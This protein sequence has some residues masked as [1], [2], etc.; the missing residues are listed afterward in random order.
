MGK[1]RS[2]SEFTIPGLGHPAI[3]GQLYDGSKDSFVSTPQAW[4]DQEKVETYTHTESHKITTVNYQDVQGLEDRSRLLDIKGEIKLSVMSGMIDLAG[5]ASYLDTEKETI[6]TR[7]VSVACTVTSHIKR[8]TFRNGDL[9]ATRFTHLQNAG[10]THV[11]TQILYGGAIVAVF[12]ERSSKKKD[13]KNIGGSFSASIMKKLGSTLSVSA[14][15]EV[16]LEARKEANS[17][18][19]SFNYHADCQVDK[20]PTTVADLLVLVNDWGTVMGEGTIPLQI[21]LTPLSRFVD[22]SPI[23]KTLHAM[24]EAEIAFIALTYDKLITLSGKRATLTATLEAKQD[25]F[26]SLYTKSEEANSDLSTVVLDAR[27][28]LRDYLADYRQG[29]QEKKVTDFLLD[30]DE[31]L[32]GH[33]QSYFEHFTQSQHLFIIESSSSKQNAALLGVDGI[34]SKMT[35]GTGALG[36]IIIPEEFNFHEVQDLYR[37]EMNRISAWREKEDESVKKEIS[38]SAD[39]RASRA[40]ANSTYKTEFAS[41]YADKSAQERF[42]GLDNSQKTLKDAM[43]ACAEDKKSRFVYYDFVVKNG[44][45]LDKMDWFLLN[46]NGW[47]FITNVEEESSYIGEMNNKLPHG[48]GSIIYADG[49][50]Y[51]GDWWDGFRDGYGQSSEFGGGVFIRDEYFKDGVI[52]DLS[53][54]SN[55][56]VIAFHKLPLPKSATLGVI[57]S[58][59]AMRLRWSEDNSYLLKLQS[60]NNPSEFDAKRVKTK[61]AGLQDGQ[62]NS[63]DELWPVTYA[64]AQLTV[65]KL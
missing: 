60:K 32:K 12:K 20:T 58:S 23:G 21:T 34:R 28:D 49:S 36:V 47:G 57:V 35:N 1:L 38:D 46:T 5:S 2:D 62:Q 3:L 54:I 33:T 25:L 16:R 18:D 40:V 30:I 43:E 44:I 15:A 45:V 37:V 41:F 48:R 50:T 31:K 14:K 51:T 7:E 19:I 4:S 27:E 10:A 53:T 6:S 8:L 26:P 65:E 39:P 63:V 17:M 52:L 56:T 29:T 11:V 55:N 24:G 64:S 59:V 13:E 9:D 61:G 22:N 42:L